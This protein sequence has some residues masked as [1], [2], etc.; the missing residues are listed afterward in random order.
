MSLLLITVLSINGT[1]SW[2]EDVSQVEFHAADLSSINVNIVSSWAKTRRIFVSDK[3]VYQEGYDSAKWLPTY[4]GRLFFGLKN[5]LDK[6]WELTRVGSSNTYYVDIPAIYNNEPVVFL[7]CSSTGWGY[8]DAEKVFT[9]NHKTVHYWNKWETIFPNTFHSETYTVY[10]TDFATWEESSS[11]HSVYFVNSAFFN[12]VY[13][14]MWDSHSVITGQTESSGIQA[15]VV[16]NDEWPGKKMTTEM[17]AKTSSQSLKTYA[18]FYNSDYDRIIFNDGDLVS[19]ANQEYQT[20]DLWLT[21]SQGNPL[22]LVDGTFDMTTLTWFH[23]NPTNYYRTLRRYNSIGNERK[24]SFQYR[25][26]SDYEEYTHP[27]R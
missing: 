26:G 23:T 14:Y 13:D 5:N 11:V 9:S 10:S 22:N 16:K 24:Y 7:R 2:I 3:T 19:G 6:N 12:N 21:D 18:F 1:A 20:Q 17:K 8:G 27:G 4:G 15:K 25:S